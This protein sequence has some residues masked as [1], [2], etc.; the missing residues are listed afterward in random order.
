MDPKDI[1]ISDPRK[2]PYKIS[3]IIKQSNFNELTGEQLFNS[4]KKN[5]DYTGIQKVEKTILLNGCKLNRVMLDPS[6]DRSTGW[7]IGE[8]RGDLQKVGLGMVSKFLIDMMGGIMTG[9]IIIIILANGQLLII[10]WV[11]VYLGI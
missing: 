7:G 3:A 9:L 4:L 6:G 5:I 2:G 11:P 10:V 8:M 1:V